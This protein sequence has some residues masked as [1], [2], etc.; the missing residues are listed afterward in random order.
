MPKL[1]AN[2]PP[3]V[4]P[5]MRDVGHKCRFRESAWVGGDRIH[6]GRPM[7]W[8]THEVCNT[9]RQETPMSINTARLTH[10]HA[11][12]TPVT[13]QGCTAVSI[14]TRTALARLLGQFWKEASTTNQ[15]TAATHTWV[16]VPPGF[17]KPLPQPVKTRTRTKGT[18]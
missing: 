10:P 16:C 5:P 2:L 8:E 11:L 18:G 15:T 13:L 9:K 4:S 3:G 7:V 14:D 6:K 17:L 1:I 12:T